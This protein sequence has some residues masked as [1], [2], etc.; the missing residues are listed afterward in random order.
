[1]VYE[2]EAEGL[3]ALNNA[4][5]SEAVLRLQG[6]EALK[7]V[8]DGRAT[9][10]FVPTDITNTVSSLGVIGETLGIGSA[11]PVDDSEKEKPEPKADPCVKPTTSKAGKEAARKTQELDAVMCE[12]FEV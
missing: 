2:A 9:K 10:I 7:D 4:K 1:M 12:Q 5:I 8:A 3:A 6:I 11:V